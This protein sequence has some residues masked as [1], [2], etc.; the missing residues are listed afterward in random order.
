[1]K[2]AILPMILGAVLGA[3]CAAGAAATDSSFDERMLDALHEQGAISEDRYRE[4]KR[5][6]QSADHPAPLPPVASAAQDPEAWT[7]SW[8][9]GFRIER[10]DGL[11][12]LKLGGR[13]QVDAAYIAPNNALNEWAMLPTASGGLD[14]DLRGFGAELRRARMFME[15]SFFEHGAFKAEYDFAGGDADFNDVWVG[16]QKLPYVG[17]VRVGHVKEGFSLNQQTSSKYITFMERALPSDAFA[18]GRNTGVALNN[19]AFEERMSWNVGGFAETGAYGDRDRS[20]RS[21]YNVTTRLTGLPLYEDGGRELIHLGLG[22]THKFL[23][24]TIGYGGREVHLSEDL[25]DTGDILAK[26]ADQLGLE[27]ASVWGPL[28]LQAEWMSAWVSQIGGD[29]LDF[30][31]VYVQ[32]SW[33]VTGESRAYNRGGGHFDRVKPTHRFAPARGEWGA[34]E[35]ASRYSYL[36]LN[37]ENIRGGTQNNVTLGANWYLYSNLRLML[38]WVHSHRNGIGDQDAVQTRLAVDF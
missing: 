23:N 2:R 33:F 21:N 32:A 15:G 9:N 7:A 10:N 28:S 30:T 1:M 14:E 18:L 5:E 27:F 31:G 24:D 22:Y 16:L 34:L 8:N 37:D 26:G 17:R 6:V 12:K 3:A 35:L 29:D 36:D 20:N 38:N 19:T 13:V 4:L 25:V 11:F